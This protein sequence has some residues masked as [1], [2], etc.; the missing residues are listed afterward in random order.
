[1][2]EIKTYWG[3]TKNDVRFII[4]MEAQNCNV[5]KAEDPSH[6]NNT[7]G[8]SDR[9]QTLGKPHSQECVECNCLNRGT[10]P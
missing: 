1:V 7:L 2:K 5:C 6:S 10:S 3:W 4:V 9:M 8:D